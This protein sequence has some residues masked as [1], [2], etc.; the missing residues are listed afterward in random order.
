MV[1]NYWN[2]VSPKTRR[3]AQNNTTSIAILRCF[4]AD[5]MTHN[6]NKPTDGNSFFSL[7]KK[8]TEQKTIVQDLS[9][10]THVNVVY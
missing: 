4:I 3:F 10:Y 1:C 8:K 5:V 2:K 7:K 6:C 9:L